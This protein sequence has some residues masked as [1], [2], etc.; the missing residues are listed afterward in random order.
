M[1]TDI[2][3]C[4]GH[5]EKKA[6]TLLMISRSVYRYMPQQ[7][8][9]GILRERMKELAQKKPRYGVRRLHILLK[10][11]GLV[12][13]HKRSER[14]YRQ[15]NLAIRTKPKKKLPIMLRL[16]LPVPARINDQWALDFVHDRTAGGRSFRC[17]SILDI[18]TRE[19]PAIHVDTS[20]PGKAVTD[21]LDRLTETRGK[22]QII[23]TDNGPE[24]TAKAFLSWAEKQDIHISHIHPG[25]PMENGFVESF[26]GK[27]RDEC[28]NLHWFSSLADARQKIE[29]WRREYN[30]ERPH[31]SLGDLTPYEFKEQMVLTG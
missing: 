28:L 3:Q 19:C 13:N 25:K 29:A 14:L 27:F 17:L 2:R 30:T 22:P 24:F 31:S 1:V 20:I 16:P 26:Q 18:A 7:R 6:C 15:E 5:S 12:V 4:F 11:E 10:K 23:I 21:V 9:D 8:N